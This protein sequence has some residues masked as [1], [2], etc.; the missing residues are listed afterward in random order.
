M[1]AV[2]RDTGAERERDRETEGGERVRER[3]S[4]VDIWR[5]KCNPS[6][7]LFWD[8][9]TTESATPKSPQNKMAGKNCLLKGSVSRELRGAKSGIN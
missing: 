7:E 3:E 5:T 4:E 1:L 6:V 8:L 2:N 9:M